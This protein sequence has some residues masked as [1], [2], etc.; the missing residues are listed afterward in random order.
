VEG[1]AAQQV[2]SRA[3]SISFAADGKITGDIVGWGRPPEFGTP[4]QPPD[5]ADPALCSPDNAGG[6]EE[7]STE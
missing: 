3:H 5:K 2:M 7:V 6:S 4:L 1:N